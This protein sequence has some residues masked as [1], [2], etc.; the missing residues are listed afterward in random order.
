MGKLL[1]VGVDTTVNYVLQETS[2]YD[3]ANPAATTA[4]WTPQ[5]DMDQA[6]TIPL[7]TAVTHTA[8]GA[9]IN[10]Q[11]MAEFNDGVKVKLKPTYDQD[12]GEDPYLEVWTHDEVSSEWTIRRKIQL[13]NGF[14]GVE[15]GHAKIF[16]L[17]FSVGLSNVDKIWIT[18]NP[19]AI[20]SPSMEFVAIQVIGRCSATIVTPG[21]CEDDPD[22]DCLD[23][24]F[25][26]PNDPATCEDYGLE[27]DANGNCVFPP[28]DFPGLPPADGGP[29][30]KPSTPP[31][32]PAV[33]LCDAAA[34]QA[35]KDQLTPEQLAYFE[36]LLEASDLPCLEDPDDPDEPLQPQQV[37]P[38]NQD[39]DT[40]DPILPSQPIE[41]YVDPRTLEPGPDPRAADDS[42]GDPF[43][44]VRQTL[45]AVVTWSGNDTAEAVTYANANVPLP[46]NNPTTMQLTQIQGNW[47]PNAGIST[48][49][50]Q[51]TP[52]CYGFRINVSD[53]PYACRVGLRVRTF[54][55]RGT[56]DLRD[57]INADGVADFE[58]GGD[59]PT[60]P[61]WILTKS[62]T[63]EVPDSNLI[64]DNF[65]ELAF[66]AESFFDSDDRSAFIDIKL[67]RE[68]DTQ[69]DALTC[70]PGYKARSRLGFQRGG[71]LMGLTVIERDR[72]LYDV[73]GEDYDGSSVFDYIH[74]RPQALV[75]DV[76]L[77]ASLVG[78]I[79]DVRDSDINIDMV[80]YKDAQPVE[81]CS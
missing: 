25:G 75:I 70:T 9:L 23:P 60:N 74:R 21:S 52:A 32:F 45:R 39:P 18:M 1:R 20:G 63:L 78:D 7:P 40:G 42:R 26:D 76:V 14:V 36:E 12:A 56:A 81:D 5:S 16:D 19:G 73:S 61:D 47:G 4:T 69:N 48:L 31:N 66:K 58:P 62:D 2:A 38:I 80:T 79:N 27:T 53:L 67:P 13:K 17:P 55:L 33:D 44:T 24:T 29:P 71:C 43:V 11:R 51:F 34:L 15:S 77:R 37:L 10:F 59:C 22:V 65:Y 72:W 3:E 57:S 64:G 46:P 68:D 35:F 50:V 30:T 6:L 8:Q 41:V 54:K 28:P 49:G